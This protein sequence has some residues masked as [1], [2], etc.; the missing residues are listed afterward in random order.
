MSTS[1]TPCSSSAQ[2]NKITAENYNVYDVD[3]RAKASGAV[4]HPWP[5]YPPAVAED[6]KALC[7]VAGVGSPQ[8]CPGT[9]CLGPL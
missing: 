6:I 5:M 4:M 2:P 3:G 1:R 7:E 8:G 9:L